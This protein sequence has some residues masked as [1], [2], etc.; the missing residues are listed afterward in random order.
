[1][2]THIPHMELFP[3]VKGILRYGESYKSVLF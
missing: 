1:M 3:T 2:G